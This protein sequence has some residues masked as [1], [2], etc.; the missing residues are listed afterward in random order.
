MCVTT[1][2]PSGLFLIP[3]EQLMYTM[4]KHKNRREFGCTPP[5]ILSH[6][7]GNLSVRAM[8]TITFNLRWVNIALMLMVESIITKEMVPIFCCGGLYLDGTYQQWNLTSVS[9]SQNNQNTQTSPSGLVSPV[10]N[11]AK[12]S[13]K[14]NDNGWTGYHDINRNVSTSTP[15]YAISDGTAYF[16]QYSSNGLLRSYGNYIRFKS[17]DGVYEVRYAHLSRFNGAATPI[18]KSASFPCSGAS[19]KKLLSSRNASA[20]EVLGYI[21]STGNSSGTHLHIEVYKNGQRIDPT[22]IF[23][24]LA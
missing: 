1:T 22:S 12:F 17:A 8:A 4:D 19:Q 9:S 21:G 5:I 18:T 3:H 23:P 10:P 11:G 20:G 24:Q 2:T 13:K 7:F 14:T 15:V 6:S 16:Y